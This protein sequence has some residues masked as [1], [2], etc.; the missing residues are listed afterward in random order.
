MMQELPAPFRI[1][2]LGKEFFPCLAQFLEPRGIFRAKL[3]F[4]LAANALSQ[5]GA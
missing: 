4:E 3:F 2:V 1:D 5:C